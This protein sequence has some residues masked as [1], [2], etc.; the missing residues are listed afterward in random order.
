MYGGDVSMVPIM[1]YYPRAAL[2]PSW[3]DRVPNPAGG[4]RLTIREY[5]TRWLERLASNA[6]ELLGTY[7]AAPTS[8]AAV[9]VLSEIP[10]HEPDPGRR[11]DLRSVPTLGA[12]V[13]EHP[14]SLRR[15]CRRRQ[16]RFPPPL[17]PHPILRNRR[18]RPTVPSRSAPR[19][20]TTFAA[21]TIDV[22]VVT[23][24]EST[25][26]LAARSVPPEIE[27]EDGLGSMRTIVFPVL[28]PVAYADGWGDATIWEDGT[29]RAPTSW[30]CGCNRS[31]PSSTA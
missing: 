16:S 23:V 10:E 7:V 8:P 15:S 27:V 4:N 3:M 19:R 13:V 9:T 30:V 17:P 29:T 2:D 6:T 25:M 20:T 31:S 21:P 24:S 22:D 14:A 11:R 28:G 18:R 5:Q 12:P 1:W 26:D